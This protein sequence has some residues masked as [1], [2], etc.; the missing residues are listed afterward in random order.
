[1]SDIGNYGNDN[2]Y[3]FAYKQGDHVKLKKDAYFREREKATRLLDII[4]AKCGAKVLLYQKD[5]R[6]ELHRCYLD[7][8]LDPLKYEKLQ[9]I[10]NLRKEDMPLLTCGKCNALIGYPMLH[11]EGRLAY[12][13]IKGAYLKRKSKIIGE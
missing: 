5:G 6:G 4:C 12:F 2:E 11:R 8:I 9:H 10:A 3:T 7:R 1:M 13:L